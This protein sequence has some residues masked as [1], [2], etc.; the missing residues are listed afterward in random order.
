MPRLTYTT[1]DGA[2]HTHE[3]KAGRTRIGRTQDNDLQI[4]ELEISAHH[5]EL[6]LTERTLTVRDLDSASG[7]FVDGQPTREGTLSPG[8]VL[9][10]GTFLVSVS[11]S[12]GDASATPTP[13]PA[14]VKLKDGSYSCLR[15]PNTRAAYECTTCYELSCDKCVPPGAA[16][17]CPRCGGKCKTIDWSGLQ[18][19]RRD[20]LKDLLVPKT[21]KQAIGL[22]EKYKHRFF[23]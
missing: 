7:I 20:A 4:D 19:S 2:V 22:W 16:P 10:L 17:C 12:V 9:C 11:E 1:F 15:H 13:A 23:K 18:Q 6:H 3:L 8:Q 14:P 5:C 21:A